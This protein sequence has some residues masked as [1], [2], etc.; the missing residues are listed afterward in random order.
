MGV[1]LLLSKS[2]PPAL[3]LLLPRL[4]EDPDDLEKSGGVVIEIVGTTTGPM[5]GDD[6]AEKDE[7]SFK[8]GTPVET[9]TPGGSGVPGATTE[10]G[11]LVQMVV[12]V[13]LISPR[14]PPDS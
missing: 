5:I 9:I 6:D 2:L 8:G 7:G 10:E 12:L 11:A 14:R 3:L 13:F 4:L 1:L